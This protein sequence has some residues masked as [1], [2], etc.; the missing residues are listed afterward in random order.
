MRCSHREL[1][2]RIEKI[3]KN[4]QRRK[5][6]DEEEDIAGVIIKV[7]GRRPFSNISLT[8]DEDSVSDGGSEEE[9]TFMDWR[10]KQF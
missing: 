5:S 1:L 8:I 4:E 10:A 3:R 6:E 7:A 9:D 2:E